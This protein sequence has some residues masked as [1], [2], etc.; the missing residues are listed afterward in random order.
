[1]RRVRAAAIR[2]N[3]PCS[4][5]ALAAADSDTWRRSTGE[6]SAG[7]PVVAHGRAKPCV[8]HT[9][10]PR[11]RSAASIASR[12]DISSSCRS[13]TR[14]SGAPGWKMS[15]IRSTTSTTTRWLST[16]WASR[17]LPPGRTR[18]MHGL[19]APPRSA[20]RVKARTN[21]AV[22]R[23]HVGVSPTIETA[24]PR[25]D[26]WEPTNSSVTLAEINNASSSS[27]QTKSMSASGRLPATATAIRPL[28]SMSSNSTTR[29]Q[30]ASGRPW[31]SAPRSADNVRS[32][33]PRA[34][35]I[36]RAARAGVTATHS[37]GV[38][39]AGNPMTVGPKAEPSCPICTIN[40]VPSP[41]PRSSAEPWRYGRTRS[42]GPTTSTW[43]DALDAAQRRI[44]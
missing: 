16:I 32:S 33:R 1:M 22:T 10:L 41:S 6:P 13:I 18:R 19:T 35:T 15:S 36:R 20:E 14:W 3:G 17:S 5:P 8:V 37:I 9:T 2:P 31:S 11:R 27:G 24:Q 42:V 40:S 28:S 12:V 4:A 39:V 44:R 29:L 38:G 7:H 21:W 30:P 34:N 23:S 43:P 25:S 26:P